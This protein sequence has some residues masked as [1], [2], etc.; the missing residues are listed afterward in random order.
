MYISIK[1]NLNVMMPILV[2][3]KKFEF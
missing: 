1:E 3:Q 2:E